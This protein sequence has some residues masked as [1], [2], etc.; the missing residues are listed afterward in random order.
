MLTAQEIKEKNFEKAVFGG[1]DMGSVDSFMEAIAADYTAMQKEVA[2]LKGKMKVLVDKI[3]EYRETEDA[4][5]LAL[6]TAQKT[7]AQIQ[8]EAQEKSDRLLAETE[9]KCQEQRQRAELEANRTLS[10]VRNV[11]EVEQTRVDKAR[12]SSGAYIARVRALCAEQL[13]FLDELDSLAPQDI[14]AELQDTGADEATRTAAYE[15]ADKNLNQL[16]DQL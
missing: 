10:A 4:M 8:A 9:R 12:A 2:V 11:V 5:R 13:R 14:A 1:Y 7:G 6:S 15:A 16:A 3:E